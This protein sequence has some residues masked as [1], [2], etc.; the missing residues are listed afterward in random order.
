MKSRGGPPLWLMNSRGGPT[1]LGC[2]LMN[3]RGG[4][5]ILRVNFYRSYGTFFSSF[6]G[7]QTL[8]LKISNLTNHL[9]FKTLVYMGCH[10]SLPT[11]W[12]R[13]LVGIDLT[14]RQIKCFF[15]TLHYV[16]INQT[17]ITY[18]KWPSRHNRLSVLTSS[19]DVFTNLFHEFS[20]SLSSWILV[21]NSF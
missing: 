21:W 20:H 15:A 14:W 4:P 3:S 10:K 12:Y 9:P 17:T 13:A 16:L 8:F 5:P 7:H 6:R 11:Y 18:L 2:M 19:S 1:F